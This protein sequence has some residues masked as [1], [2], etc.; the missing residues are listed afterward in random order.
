METYDIKYSQTNNPF[1]LKAKTVIWHSL[2][3]KGYQKQRRK[4]EMVK[5]RINSSGKLEGHLKNTLNLFGS[6][7]QNQ[8]I[9]CLAA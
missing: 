2:N 3:H 1:Q 7:H 4:T 8:T 5:V 6:K 9:A